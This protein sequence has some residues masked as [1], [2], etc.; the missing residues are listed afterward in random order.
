MKRSVLKKMRTLKET[1]KFRK[2]RPPKRTDGNIVC[3]SY[4]CGIRRFC[5]IALERNQMTP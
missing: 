2:E 1:R 4:N 3:F 5:R